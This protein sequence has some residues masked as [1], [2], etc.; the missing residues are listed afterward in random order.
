[1]T[2]IRFYHLQQKNIEQALPEILEKALE[3][4]YKIVIKVSDKEEVENID[5]FIWT[6][7]KD[8]FI[9]HGYKKNGTEKEQPI[10]ITTKDENPNSANMLVLVNS[11]SS[12]EIDNFDLCCKIFDGNQSEIVETSR[13]QWKEY[14]EKN[15][16]LSYFQQDVSGRWSKKA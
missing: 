5:K 16:N 14:K 3:H 4:D 8:S 13:L 11:T 7:K 2:E 1:M 15:Y 6:Y 9:P 12:T 10:W